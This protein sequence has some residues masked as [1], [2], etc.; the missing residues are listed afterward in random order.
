MKAAT[1]E[2]TAAHHIL[3]R[4]V[5]ITDEKMKIIAILKKTEGARQ[6]IKT[7]A[8]VILGGLFFML[9]I[10]GPQRS[11]DI[12]SQSVSGT[13]T[14][15]NPKL[16]YLIL[17]HE[18]QKR[19]YRLGKEVMENLVNS[20]IEGRQM[21]IHYQRKFGSNYITRLKFQRAMNAGSLKKIVKMPV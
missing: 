21:I 9:P 5:N 1:M 2:S 7:A 10:I 12:E 3:H 4:M 19:I 15:C 17:E 20:G 6:K 16:G 14:S 18:G 11:L 13:V 8:I